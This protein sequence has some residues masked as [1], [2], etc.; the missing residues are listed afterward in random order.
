MLFDFL[1]TRSDQTF[2]I[3]KF[4]AFKPIHQVN[5]LLRQFER[6]LLEC[7]LPRRILH[8]KPEVNMQQ[9]PESTQHYVSVVSILHVKDVAENGVAGQRSDEIALGLFKL[10]PVVPLVKQF[11]S[12]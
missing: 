6:C 1:Q 5:I 2:K 11:Q 12:V 3:S 8:H 7:P 10:G 9:M 4:V